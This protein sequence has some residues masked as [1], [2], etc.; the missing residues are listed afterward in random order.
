M[1]KIIYFY[2][3]TLLCLLVSCDN[4][5]DVKPKG[6]RIPST[7]EDYDLL[8]T[9]VTTLYIEPELFLSADDFE[10]ELSNLGDITHPDNRDLHLYTY[11]AKRFANPEIGTEAWNA[12][13]KNLY[14]YN[15][16]INEIDDA[17][18]A[19][20]YTSEH[21]TMIK[22]QALYGRAGQYFFLV[23]MFAKHYNR[24][25]ASLDLAVPILLEA[26]TSQKTPPRSTVQKVYEQIEKDLLEAIPS[27]PKRRTGINKP[28]K[29]SGYALLSRVYLYKGDYKKALENAELAIKENGQLSDYTQL[30]NINMLR[31]AYASEQY[32]ILT[33]GNTA[34]FT[35]GVVTKELKELYDAKDDDVRIK[36]VVMCQYVLNA[37]GTAYVQDCEK[38]TNYGRIQ[39]NPMPSVAEMYVTAAECYARQGNTVKSLERLNQLRK[40]RI[41]SVV[42][43]T[44]ADFGKAQ[45]L[46]RFALEERRRELFMSGT[47]LFDVKRLNLEPNYA[48]IIKHRLKDDVYEAAPNSGKLVFPIPAQIKEF[49][50]SF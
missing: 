35:E 33:F 41:K 16:V 25:T 34:G 5:L 29:G 18:D 48:K 7:I 24:A 47:R 44:S 50:P 12:P 49:N 30:S 8:L 10:P 42:A 4:Y 32:S 43:K 23:N 45:E 17:T 39:P 2:T 19:I 26:S 36:G 21:K 38:R 20:G 46:V 3:A 22:A 37:D 11:S 28:S 31:E 27:L 1:K 9:P 13:Y 15:K 40:H 6:Q 14:V